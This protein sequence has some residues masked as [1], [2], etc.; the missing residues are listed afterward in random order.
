MTTSL[1]YGAFQI[2]D[3]IAQWSGDARVRVAMQPSTSEYC[4]LE[5]VWNPDDR[6]FEGQAETAMSGLCLWAMH[7]CVFE[8]VPRGKG[9]PGARRSFASHHGREDVFKR[10]ERGDR[11][12]HIHIAENPFGPYQIRLMRWQSDTVKR[13]GIK[14]LYY[15]LPID[16]YLQSAERLSRY[17]GWHGRAERL[18]DMIRRQHDALRWAIRAMIECEVAFI[19]PLRRD[20][21]SVEE[22]WVWPYLNLEL[23][24]GIEEME[25]VR[26]AYEARQRGAV[27]P[28][29]LLGALAERTPYNEP[30]IEGES[31]LL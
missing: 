8:L 9:N 18:E 20:V 3:G 26:I 27:V 6:P 11:V 1:K 7:D 17:E 29:I 5:G 21:T 24:L 10:I 13:L 23:D 4:L 28:P 19:H 12:A 25:E 30:L 2:A 14:K 15:A 16:E 22:S 31:I